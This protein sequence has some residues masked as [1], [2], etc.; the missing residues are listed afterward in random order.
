MP[1]TPLLPLKIFSKSAYINL[2]LVNEKQFW[3]HSSKM[4][5]LQSSQWYMNGICNSG[6][7]KRYAN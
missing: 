1:Y 2:L 3:F 6:Q 4:M 5:G 7:W